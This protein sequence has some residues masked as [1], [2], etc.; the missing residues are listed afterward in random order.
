MK[1]STDSVV[2]DAVPALRASKHA[3]ATALEPACRNKTIKCGSK[4]GCKNARRNKWAEDVQGAA[5]TTDPMPSYRQDVHPV[6]P[7]AQV[8]ERGFKRS[9]EK[10]IDAGLSC[11][12]SPSCPNTSGV[13]VVLAAIFTSEAA[14]FNEKIKEL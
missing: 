6:A 9:R 11:S 2:L 5:D 4:D 10:C 7:A 13:S 3:I 1:F 14:L 8:R 12:W